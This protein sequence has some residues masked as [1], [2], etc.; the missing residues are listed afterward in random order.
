MPICPNCKSEFRDGITVCTDCREALIEDPVEPNSLESHKFSPRKLTEEERALMKPTLLCSLADD[1]SSGMLIESLR[2]SGIPVLIKRP[3]TGEYLSIYMGMNVFG[4]DV[5]VPSGML[6]DAQ[7]ILNDLVFS[8]N[9][10]A[11]EYGEEFEGEEFEGEE[12]E[13]EEFEDEEV[14]TGI[15][16]NDSADSADGSDNITIIMW[17]LII[18]IMLGMF[19]VGSVLK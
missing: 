6:D 16:S 19:G 10:L 13:G 2:E 15:K 11:D 18:A 7:L 9:G 3:G 4:V 12:F 1:V 8:G 14:E 17:L 5:Y